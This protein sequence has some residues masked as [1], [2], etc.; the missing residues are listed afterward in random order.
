MRRTLTGSIRPATSCYPIVK[1][2]K[3]P[4]AASWLVKSEPESYSWAD[5]MRDRHTAWT[6]V[7]NFAARNHLKAMQRGDRVLFYESGG[8]KAVVGIAEVSRTAFPDETADEPGWVAVELKAV[9][10]LARAVTLSQIKS[11]PVLANM[12]L[13]RIGRLSVQPVTPE[14]FAKIEKLGA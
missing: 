4:A 9:K 8:P 6:G 1:S 11:E 10:P 5:L 13:V 14:E 12:A 2:A 3:S 7:R